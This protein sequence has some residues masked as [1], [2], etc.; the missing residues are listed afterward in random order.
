MRHIKNL[1]LGLG[2]WGLALVVSG[3]PAYD[4]FL[5]ANI[6]RNYVVGSKIETL[7][8][9]YQRTADD[10]WKHIGAND[11]S[12][13]AVA[14]E[15]SNRQVI[16]TSAQTGL[17]RSRDGGQSWRLVNG[18]DMTEARDLAVDQNAKGHV[19]LALADGVAVSTDGGQTIARREH[20][21]PD[22][23][24][25]TQ[26]L[27]ID[28]TRAGRVL[29]AC[30]IGIFLT[31]DAGQNW[32]PVFSTKETV[33]DIQ[34][35]PHDP[36]MWIA[37]TQSAGAVRSADG[38]LTWTTM[39]EVP[40]DHALYNLTF[41]VTRPERLAIGSW[42]HGVMTSEDNGKTWQK[43]NAGLPEPHRVWRVGVDPKGRL[44]A[45]VVEETLFISDD[46]GRTWRPD[47]LVGSLVNNFVLVPKSAP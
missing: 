45:S 28:R 43:R 47:T 2:L 9:V 31:E 5:C 23:G 3:A 15:P 7:N 17:W 30:E 25:F 41:D 13:T 4:F 33:N 42:G 10:G 20:G 36:L 11:T 35:S 34:Q 40:R 37:V 16:Y 24:K 27:Q 21:L 46:F 26:A 12:I 22:R 14:F 44:Y 29:A 32:R 8:G 1:V 18:W 6:N 19:Y 39:P 38:G